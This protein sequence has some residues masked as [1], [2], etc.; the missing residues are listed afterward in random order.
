MKSKKLSIFFA[1][2][3][4][5]EHINIIKSRHYEGIKRNKDRE[6]PPGGIRW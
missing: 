3:F 4:N 5:K 6:E 1:K 2:E